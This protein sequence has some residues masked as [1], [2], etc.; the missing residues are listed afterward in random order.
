MNIYNQ[1]LSLFS[2]NFAVFA[3]YSKSDEERAKTM[4]IDELEKILKSSLGKDI[5]GL[6]IKD[7]VYKCIICDNVVTYSARINNRYCRHHIHYAPK[8]Y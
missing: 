3:W 7:Y 1:T 5:A 4:S 2:H 8:R 6:L